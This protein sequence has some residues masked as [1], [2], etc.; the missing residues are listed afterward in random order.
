MRRGF[1]GREYERLRG[2]LRA[3]D[4]RFDDYWGFLEPR[5]RR[6]VAPARRRRH[7]L[8]AP[9]LPRGALR[10]GA[11]R[12]AVR[13]RPLPQ[14]ADLGLRLRREDAQALADQ[15]RHD[16]RVREGSGP[17][18]G[19]TRT[20]STASRTWRPVSS[21]PRRRRA[22]SCPPT[23]GGTRS[24]RRR[25]ARRRATRRRS[26]RAILRRIVQASSRPGDR[27]LDFFAG[28]GTT[29]AVAVGARP[30]R[31]AR[32]RRTPRRSR[33]CGHGCRRPGHRLMA[34]EPDDPRLTQR[35]A[36]RSSISSRL[37]SAARAN[38][39]FAN[40]ICSSVSV[41]EVVGP[42]LRRRGR[43]SG[44][45]CSS[46]VSTSRG[47]DDPAAVGRVALARDVAGPL[48]PVDDRGDGAARGQAG[49][50]GELARRGRALAHQQ[51]DRLHVGAVDAAE[52]RDRVL[53]EHGARHELAHDLGHA[54]DRCV[55]R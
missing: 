3:Y 50:L 6:G 26:P 19:S 33:S 55:P 23:S 12:R 44:R 29:G 53:E 28:S 18:T 41:V 14:R 32:R 52:P 45:P 51:A 25:A 46:T 54:L 15:A 22:A 9:R 17:R 47:D 20:P 35:H 21:R 39:S 27:V 38:S 10:E 31:R 34:V 16:P 49:A 2:D 5:L 13:P 4:D 7:A 36:S 43:R 8:P 42:A 24:C 48:E 30:R 37:I 11:A 1:H 40:S